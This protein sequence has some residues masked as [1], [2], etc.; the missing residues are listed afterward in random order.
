MTTTVARVVLGSVLVISLA[1][2]C[3]VAAQESA[4][5]AALRRLQVDSL[6]GEITVYF[7]PGHRH[8]AVALQRLYEAG[9]RFY[10][11]T[12][13]HDFEV[14]LAVLDSAQLAAVDP[15][16]AYGFPWYIRRG[17][18][19]IMVMPAT[20]H[21]GFVVDLL[22]PRFGDDAARRGLE[23]VGFHELGHALVQ[24]YL[25]PGDTLR[26]PPVLWFDE[27]MATYVGQGY[28]WMTV[29]GTL[30]QA[31][32]RAQ[33]IRAT[34]IARPSITSL[35]HF[36]ANAAAL[37]HVTYAWYEGVFAARASEIFERRGLDFLHEIRRRLPWDQIDG[38]TS[39]ALLT[40]LDDIE[41]GFSAWASSL[42]RRQ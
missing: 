16:R 1:P 31:R 21:R 41:P 39:S 11:D 27:L 15:K 29:P 12:L 34:G 36:E 10:E 20:T 4:S 14:G 18:T 7:T 40:W 9:L 38:W 24:E 23:S 32:Q 25:Y 13:S 33:G 3:A 37:D 28:Q 26:R 6:A 17:S 42:E 22:R 8:R 5:A 2:L 19:P 30:Q 35:A